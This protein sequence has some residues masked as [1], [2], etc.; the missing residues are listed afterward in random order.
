MGNTIFHLS[1][2]GSTS[3][4]SQTLKKREREKLP[5]SPKIEN[6]RA[7]LAVVLRKFCS[8]SLCLPPQLFKVVF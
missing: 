5:K 3:G 2:S 7:I 1:W 6:N 4:L 8:T